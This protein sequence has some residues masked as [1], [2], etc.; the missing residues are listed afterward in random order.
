MTA[1]SS[2][3]QQPGRAQSGAYARDQCSERVRCI[4]SNTLGQGR[5]YM[6]VL[7]TAHGLFGN[8]RQ[9]IFALTIL[10]L[11]LILYSNSY[12]L[13]SFPS[14]GEASSFGCSRFSSRALRRYILS[15]SVSSDTF[16]VDNVFKCSS[17]YSKF[18]LFALGWCLGCV[19]THWIWQLVT[20][21]NKVAFRE[22]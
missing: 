6:H 20:H 4:S 14:A 1:S 10:C 19:V 16:L 15:R 18:W 17:V 11:R 3:C 5:L 2:R 7:N 9:C 8:L 21:L 12:F 13:V 22:C